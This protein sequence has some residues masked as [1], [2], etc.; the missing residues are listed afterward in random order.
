M[1]EDGVAITLESIK[2]SANGQWAAD[3]AEKWLHDVRLEALDS[4]EER[5]EQYREEYGAQ[6]LAPS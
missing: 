4:D 3:L 6:D 1:C 5:W 2:T